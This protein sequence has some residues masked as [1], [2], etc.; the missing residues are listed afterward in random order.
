MKP[1]PVSSVTEIKNIVNDYEVCNNRMVSGDDNG[2]EVDRL[3]Q[4]Y[5]Q[6]FKEASLNNITG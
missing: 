1:V 3:I 2:V 4:I 6:E 5:P